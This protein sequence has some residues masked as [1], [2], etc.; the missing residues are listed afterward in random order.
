MRKNFRANQ[1]VHLIM[2]VFASESVLVRI[3]IGYNY[4]P[5]QAD[6]ENPYYIWIFPSISSTMLLLSTCHSQE[7]QIHLTSRKKN[8]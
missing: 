2:K 5:P 7:M 4:P 3:P 8:N 1:L 6:P